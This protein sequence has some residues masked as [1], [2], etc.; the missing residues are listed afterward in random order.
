[1]LFLLTQPEHKKDLQSLKKKKKA[2][3]IL[4]EVIPNTSCLSTY[5]L[6]IHAGAT[7]LFSKS[8]F[9]IINK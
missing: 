7:A 9:I 3:A 6:L 4:L 1:M 8:L 2:A 5:L